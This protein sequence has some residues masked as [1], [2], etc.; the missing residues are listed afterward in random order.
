LAAVIIAVSAMLANITAGQ[1]ISA[2]LRR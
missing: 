1:R 2:A